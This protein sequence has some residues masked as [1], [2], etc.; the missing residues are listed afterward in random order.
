M[1]ESM[2]SHPTHECPLS[3]M[4]SLLGGSGH[5]RRDFPWRRTEP[6]PLGRLLLLEMCLHRTKAEQVARVADELLSLG[7][8][9]DSCS[10]ITRK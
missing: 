7:E 4:T 10:G 1:L 9:P 3:E 5:N 2:N 8:T 6:E